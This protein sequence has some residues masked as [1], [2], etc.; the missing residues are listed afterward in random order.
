MGEAPGQQARCGHWGPALR[1]DQ[2]LLG[3][4]RKHLVLGGSHSVLVC[5]LFPEGV[6]NDQ[7]AVL[8]G[9]WMLGSWGSVG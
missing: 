8:F 7:E 3:G 9:T 1:A 5:L 6:G 4:E 2:E